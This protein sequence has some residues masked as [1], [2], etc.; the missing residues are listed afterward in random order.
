[1][2]ELVLPVNVG[3]NFAESYKKEWGTWRKNIH[4][5]MAL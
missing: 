1:M 2:Q 5:V 3:M 4:R